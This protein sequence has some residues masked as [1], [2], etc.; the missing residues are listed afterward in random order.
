MKILSILFFVFTFTLSSC[1]EYTPKPIGYARIE[2]VAADTVRLQASGFSFL[3][4]SLA[5]IEYLNPEVKNEVWFNICYP[6]YKAKIY[7]T[8]IPT[9]N[10]ELPK[11]LDDSHQLAYSHAVRAESISQTQFSDSLKH[12]SGLIYDIKGS[13]ASPVQF[14][15]TNNSSKFMRGALY[16]NDAVKSDSIVP[17]VAFLRDDIVRIMESLQW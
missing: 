6:T 15:V 8:Y 11:M 3:Y 10:K 13:V 7:C 2:K 17:V 12:L 14:Y 16:F 9:N 1:S 4:S 5:K